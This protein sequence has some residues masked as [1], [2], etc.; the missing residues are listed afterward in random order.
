M[1]V[2]RHSHTNALTIKS[3]TRLYAAPLIAEAIRHGR[4]GWNA[5]QRQDPCIDETL[6]D[7]AGRFKEKLPIPLHFQWLLFARRP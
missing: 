5:K 1:L 2:C 3:I 7:L 6:Q 4:Q